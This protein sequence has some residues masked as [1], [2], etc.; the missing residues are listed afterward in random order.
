MEGMLQETEKTGNGLM[1]LVL[2][3]TAEAL[4]DLL[5]DHKGADVA[6][7]DLREQGVWTDFFV[8]ATATSATH[9]DGLDRHIKEFCKKREIEILRRSRKPDALE[10]EWRVIDLGP[11]VIHLMNRRTRDFYE[12]ERLYSVTSINNP[13]SKTE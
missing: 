5:R 9:L 10:D 13:P 12:I 4:G 6:V 11:I 8:I 1:P 2:T 3:Q 7:M